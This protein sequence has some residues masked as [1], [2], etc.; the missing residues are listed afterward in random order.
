MALLPGRLS[1]VNLLARHALLLKIKTATVNGFSDPIVA[2]PAG[3]T[4]ASDSAASWTALIIRELSRSQ[5]GGFV[6]DLAKWTMLGALCA[7]DSD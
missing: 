4:A 6:L 5:T 3:S 2:A 7:P 1:C